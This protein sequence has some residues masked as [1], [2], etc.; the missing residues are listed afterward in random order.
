MGRSGERLGLCEHLRIGDG[1]CQGCIL[2]Q[3]NDLVGD[4]GQNAL[5][6]LGQNDLEEGLAPG[7][8]Q[9][10]G[11][12]ILA[13]RHRLDPAPVNLCEI[14]RVVEGKGDDD[15]RPPVGGGD[16]YSKDVVGP[17]VDH[18]QLQHEGGSPHNGDIDF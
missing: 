9:H 16:L 18:N 12:L 2:D 11:G 10:P 7:V 4:R 8:A 14:G 5:D 17:E 1:E 13:C 6:H 3:G 15:G